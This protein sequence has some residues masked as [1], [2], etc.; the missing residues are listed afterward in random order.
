MELCWLC[1]W[2]IVPPDGFS[3]WLRNGALSLRHG[4]RLQLSKC[5]LRNRLRRAGVDARP[6]TVKI[7]SVGQEC[8]THTGNIPHRQHRW[9][10]LT[11]FYFPITT[12]LS[13]WGYNPRYIVSF[14]DN[15][16][17]AVK[18]PCLATLWSCF[19]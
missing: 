4:F 5:L 17:F 6:Y 10:P 3:Q 19:P 15:L 13:H 2:H 11:C 18:E 14:S 8:P 9:F 1:C 16:I 7:N 12:F